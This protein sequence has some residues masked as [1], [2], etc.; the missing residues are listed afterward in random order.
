MVTVRLL[1]ATR[2]HKIVDVIWAQVSANT[3]SSYE[4]RDTNFIKIEIAEPCCQ[5]YYTVFTR[6]ENPSKSQK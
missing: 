1:V 2:L 3:P 5:G 4:F 6:W